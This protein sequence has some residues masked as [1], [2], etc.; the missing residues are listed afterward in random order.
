MAE[1]K[2]EIQIEETHGTITFANEV[3]AVIAGLAAS[4]VEGVAGMGGGGSLAE[5]FSRKNLGRGIRVTVNENTATIDA[6][7]V[8]RYGKKLHEVAASV[9]VSIKKALETMTGLEVPVINVFVQG[10]EFPD[11]DKVEAEPEA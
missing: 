7:I 2:N 1:K 6:T 3:L 9:Q 8:V 4:E 11:K 10:I 5:M